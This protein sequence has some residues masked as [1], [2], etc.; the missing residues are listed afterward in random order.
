MKVNMVKFIIKSSFFIILILFI[1]YFF[2]GLFNFQQKILSL[3]KNKNIVN[4]NIV[5]LTGGSNRIKE[6][7]KVVNNINKLTKTDFKILIS[8][9]GK[10]FTKAS[11]KKILTT[12]FDLNLVECCIELESIS[13]DTYSNATETYKWT[14]KN[15]IN[16]IILITSNYH[17]PRAILEFRNRMPN[18]QIFT[19]PINPK[20][21]DIKKWLNSSHTF[22]LL[23]FEYSKLL[24]ASLRL[25]IINI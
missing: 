22:S 10:G 12:D 17:M 18:Q 3:K 5:I 19:Y 23:F 25:K 2:V 20:N 11:L 14:K 15:G 24:I 16:N 8:G 9:T 13:K 7:L 6:G 4:S 1:S 21:H